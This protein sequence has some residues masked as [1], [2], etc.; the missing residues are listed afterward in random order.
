MRDQKPANAQRKTGSMARFKN[1]IVDMRGRLGANATLDEL[2]Q[3]FALGN[4]NLDD[5]STVLQGGLHTFG[6]EE[7]VDGLCRRLIRLEPQD[8]STALVWALEEIGDQATI[9]QMQRISQTP[10]LALHI[11]TD[12]AVVL[13]ALGEA[14]DLETLPTP[15][16]EDIHQILQKILDDTERQLHQVQPEERAFMLDEMFDEIGR[17]TIQ[18]NGPDMLQTLVHALGEQEKSVAADMLWVLREFGVEEEIRN[19]IDRNLEKMRWRNLIPNPEMTTATYE[20]RFD[21]AFI[22]D[23]GQKASQLQLLISWEQRPDQLILF[24][25]LIDLT[26]WG[27]GVKDFFLKPSTRNDELD[28]IIQVSKRQDIPMVAINAA[29]TRRRLGQAL[30]ANIHHARP[31]PPE[32]RRFHRLIAR[33][34]F[35]GAAPVQLPTLTTEARSPLSGKA[36]AVEDLL[37]DSMPTAGFDSEQTLNGRMLWRDFYQLHTPRISKVEVW[38]ATVAYIIGWIEGDKERTQKAVAAHYGVS[39]GSISKRAGEIWNHFLDVEQGPIAYASE[40]ARSGPVAEEM[41]DEK[42]NFA[43]L[44]Q[45]ENELETD[46]REYL[47]E[48]EKVDTKSR[49]LSRPEF[50]QLTD[51]LDFLAALDELENLTRDQSKRLQEVEQLLLL[52]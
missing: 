15:E 2:E 26:Y 23:M 27:G 22:S 21:R 13:H 48:Y 24:S 16:P 46:Y 31:L 25:F 35:D 34:L 40:K 5:A 7:M 30:Q 36:G 4:R 38:T 44:D 10:D 6:A 28:E 3:I 45:Y 33:T 52:D 50:E 18:D 1:K 51:E 41:V 14:I 49:K 37:H 20:G 43:E 9:E 8:D 11:R 39:A 42:L 47:E 17:F 12:A 32:Y 19:L 29:E